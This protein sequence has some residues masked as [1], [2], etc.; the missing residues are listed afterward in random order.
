MGAETL[1]AVVSEACRIVVYFLMVGID[2][3]TSFLQHAVG[4][5]GT[6]S[7]TQ[8]VPTRSVGYYG[9]HGNARSV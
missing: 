9:M 1:G 6:T 3:A 8:Q 5:R 7:G 4:R 2:A